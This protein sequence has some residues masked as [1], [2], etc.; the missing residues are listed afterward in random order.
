MTRIA[1]TGA[2][3]LVGSAL[4]RQ[5][6]SAVLLG[7]RDLDIT[8][9]AAVAR[10]VPE[11]DVVFNCAVVSVDDCER[12]P[13][14]ARA[15]NVVGPANLADH[16]KTLVHFSTNYVF[17][18]DEQKLYTIDD[19]PKAVNVYGA[20]KAEGE[21]AVQARAKRAFIIR[22]SWVYGRGKSNFLSTVAEKLRKGE[23]V[24][25]IR[26]VFANSTYVD[27]LAARVALI[28]Q[29]D[30]P[31]TYH[32]ANEGVHSYEIFARE[33]ARY[34]DADELLIEDVLA[35]EVVSA[36]RPRYTPMRCLVSERL[37]IPRMRDWRDALRDYL[38]RV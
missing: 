5:F 2:H 38:D 28:V 21:S 16:A 4:A 33:A 26:D 7:H 19:V 27:D 17:A 9:R 15:I 13:S 18:G 10:V 32:V 11:F 3:G 31:A 30:V 20:T 12:D 36:P 22:T 35:E 23:R 37:G 6:P 29:R 24:R 34:V 8:D 14:L 25:A 1:I